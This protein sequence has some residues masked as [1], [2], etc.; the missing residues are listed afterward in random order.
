MT[1]DAEQSLICPKKSFLLVIDMQEKLAPEI[2]NIEQ[3]RRRNLALIQSAV[4]L[5]IPVIFT[6]QYP[7]GLGSTSRTL[8]EAAPGSQIIEKVHFDA[9]AEQSLP[10]ALKESNTMQIV[11]TGTEA[12]VCVLQTALALCN[13]GYDTYL[14][15]DAAGSRTETDKQSAI[16]RLSRAG[17]VCVSTEMV[18]F[19]WLRRANTN[20][21]RE[22]LPLIRSLASESGP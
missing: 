10:V 3:I 2:L 20:K 17:V 6:E 11:V 21:F 1:K 15:V 7:K 22:L 16:D 13:H 19:E 4:Q 12:H 14:A 9:M 8:L 18:I 5:D